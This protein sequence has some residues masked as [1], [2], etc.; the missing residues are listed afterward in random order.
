M[1]CKWVIDPPE[2]WMYGFPKILPDGIKGNAERLQDWLVEQG[3]PVAK[4]GMAM[5][6]SRYWIH[7]DES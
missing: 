4:L 7:R 5:N 3:Y 2:G 6:H 1:E